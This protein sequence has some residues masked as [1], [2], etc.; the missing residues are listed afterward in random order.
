[1]VESGTVMVTNEM[2][3]EAAPAH[4][5]FEP[6]VA[7]VEVT[8]SGIPSLDPVTEDKTGDLTPSDLNQAHAATAMPMTE[9]AMPA[10]EEAVPPSGLKQQKVKSPKRVNTRLIKWAVIIL[11]PAGLAG[12]YFNGALDPLLRSPALKASTQAVMDLCQPYLLKLADKVPA[13]SKWIS[14]IPSLEDVSPEDYEALKAAALQKLPDG[15]KLALALSTA[16]IVKPSF[17]VSSN[18]PDG[19]VIDVYVEGIPDSLLNQ[20]SF[21][22]KVQATLDKKLGKTG[23]VLS[24]DNK[25]LPRGDYVVYATENPQQPDPIKAL[26]AGIPPVTAKTTAVL[27]KEL[28]LLISKPVFLGGN[29]DAIYASRLKEFHDKLRAKATEELAEVKQLEATIESQLNQTT[30]KYNQLRGLVRGGKPSFAARKAWTDFNAQWSKFEDG[31]KQGY[32]KWTDQ[33]LATEYFYG[34]IYSMV[35]GAGDAV[36]KLHQLHSDF[37]SGKTD[38]KTFEIQRGSAISVAQN[39]VAALKG[40]ISQAES[41]AP[42]PNGMPRR[43]G[44]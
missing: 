14:P 7:D 3:T 36:D 24:P 38:I 4:P 33:A 28:K 39:A 6:E 12:A 2:A 25:A 37:F 5:G 31:I 26:L 35:K 23:P 9:S 13:L 41:I 29:K 44:L 34:M 40:K 20:L 16:D 17:Y 1:M 22:G 42:T 8:G 10:L 15:P 32:A 43:E 21:H 11:I 27:P 30:T 19:A 18:L